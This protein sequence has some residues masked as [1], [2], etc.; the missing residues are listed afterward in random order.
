MTKKK[1]KNQKDM[2]KIQEIAFKQLLLNSIYNVG[3]IKFWDTWL[4]I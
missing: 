3:G 2:N 4:E 1:T